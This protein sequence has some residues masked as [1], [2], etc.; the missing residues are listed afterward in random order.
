MKFG[1]LHKTSFCDFPGKVAAVVFTQGCNFNCPFCHNR[2]LIPKNPSQPNLIEEKEIIRFLEKRRDQ[3]EGVV[4]SGGEPT[5]H[6]D[7]SRFLSLVKELGF[8]TKLDTNGSHPEII[9]NLLSKNL[10]D[11]VAMDVKAP[12]EKYAI[13][14]GRQVDISCIQKSIELITANRVP[15]QFRT[16][17]YRKK[18]TEKDIEK[19]GRKLPNPDKYLVQ[20][21]KE[22]ETS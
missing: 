14:A 22:I 9:K 5:L 10:V 20:D 16:T 11:Y 8:F 18:L 4:V 1:G 13:L 15:H 21:Y 12:F 19:I 17:W 2:Q 7:L 6:S 3:I